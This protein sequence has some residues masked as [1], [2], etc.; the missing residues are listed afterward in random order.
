[1]NIA[2][3]FSEH[4]KALSHLDSWVRERTE[5]NGGKS[6]R[7]YIGFL[8]REMDYPFGDHTALVAFIRR[9]HG[10]DWTQLYQPGAPPPEPVPGPDSPKPK[11]S[12]AAKAD[13]RKSDADV[14]KLQRRDDFLIT[15][16]VANCHADPGFLAACERWCEERQGAIIVNPVR[17]ANPRTRE[18]ETETRKGE[19]WEP[20]LA[21][22]MLES[23]LRPHPYLS[24]M[25]TKIQATSPNPLP[26]RMGGRTQ[27]RSAVFGHPQLCMR[28]VPTPQEKLPKILYSSGAVTQKF[29]S[30]TYAGDM[31]EFHH[32]H[33]AVIA[34]IRGDR[35]HLREVTWDGEKFIDI[36]RAY[37]ADRIEDAGPPAA[38]VMG[39]IHSG[40]G[41]VDPEVM[42]ATF[43]P[44]GLYDTVL[45]DNLVL[46]DLADNLAVN[47]HESHK[48]LSRAALARKAGGLNAEAEIQRVADWLNGVPHEAQIVVVP[49]NHDEFLMRW[50]EAGERGV[51]PE[52][53]MFYHWL[54]YQMLA[55]HERDS[56]FPLAL[57]VA[58]NGK[59]A[60]GVR[61]LKID[62]S[63]R[64]NGVELGMHGHL[65]PN[66]ARGSLRNL[67]Q[68]GTR[69]ITGHV[70]SPGIWQGG[71]AVGIACL[72]RMG[73]NL[74]PSGWLHTHSLLHE[75]GRRQMIHIIGEYFRG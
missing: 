15:C 66:G 36:D 55:A 50:L 13:F 35:F 24:I 5:E 2:D 46:H 31:A 21:P 54:S 44:D 64:L 26:P 68:I 67:S 74:G 37:Y 32:T 45:P 23:E 62:E 25:P 10:D 18:E 33:A 51:L 4:P 29:Y 27:A 41:K 6:A 72:Y 39:D 3:W 9:R 40:S 75:N 63:F 19:W 57:E 47:P 17:Y 14:R 65:G 11:P 48:Q 43:G 42:A 53:R 22:Y 56:E 60:P 8:Q 69:F 61:F 28:T 30:E 34:E 58:L 59:L 49:S 73:Y 71:Y 7:R 1:V 70:H 12:K 16:A 38:L 52:N 20:A